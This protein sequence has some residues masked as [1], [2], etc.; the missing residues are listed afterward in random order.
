M[1][2]TK[3]QLKFDTKQPMFTKYRSL[4]IL[5]FA[6]F[7]L[8]ALLSTLTFV[9]SQ[10]LADA[11]QELD[12]AAY[13]TVLVQQISKELLDINLQIQ[14]ITQTKAGGTGD[15]EISID[16]LPQYSIYRLQELEH[17][18]NKFSEVLNAL[19]YGGTVTDTNGQTIHIDAIS[20]PRLQDIL[21]R[22][23]AIWIPYE[24]LLDNFNKDRQQGFIRKETSDYLVE[25]TRSYNTTLQ[26]ETTHFSNYLKGIIQ[27]NTDRL[28]LVQVFG[29]GIAF[30]LFLSIVF[31]ALRQLSRADV[32]LAKAREQTAEILA[33]VNEGLFLIDRNLVIANEYSDELENIIQQSK[34]GGKTLPQVLE[35]I[36]PAK[37]LEDTKTFIDQ[38][39]SDWVVED[40]IAD[41]NPLK[42]LKVQLGAEGGGFEER[43]LDFNFSRVYNNDEIVRVLVNVMDI[44]Q[45]VLLEQ[46]LEK[47]KAQNDR[48]MEMLGT[49][50]NTESALLSNFIQTTLIRVDKINGILKTP[51]GNI[52][53]LRSKAQ[54]IYRE[55]HSLKGE[56]SALR[57]ASFVALC[58]EIESKVK[59]LTDKFDLT[60][61]DFLSMTVNLEELLNLTLFIKSL[62]ERIGY[63]D[64][65]AIKERMALSLQSI[66]H[67]TQELSDFEYDGDDDI[68][69]DDNESKKITDIL[70]AYFRNFAQDIAHRHNK[71]V[72]FNSNGFDEVHLSS[73]QQNIIKDISIQLIRNA[74][75]HGI[76]TPDV[77]QAKDKPTAGRVQLSLNQ[78]GNTLNLVFIDDG[79]GINYDKI[80]QKAI[81][82]GHDADE[83]AAWEQRGLLNL[84]FKPGFSTADDVGE[85]AGRG[86]GMDIIKNLAKEL[87]GV[88]KVSSK[89]DQYTRFT[90]SFP[91]HS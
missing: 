2:D 27:L 53:I 57:L 24:G 81:E 6:F 43:Y 41:L 5:S 48:Q 61:A 21:T 28:R 33:T 39:Y 12:S 13:Q 4:I 58:Q 80:R 44:T 30:L 15:I 42:R 56:A 35:N 52:E 17:H 1:S 46:R 55:I 89:P 11:T 85:D 76:E 84:L 73:Q 50:V 79:Q 51:G 65:D 60:G 20:T 75:V 18:A 14:N 63:I 70:S 78:D 26:N 54:D 23:E 62:S 88:L 86:V 87:D 22:I 49:I 38:L 9:A 45:A 40:L 90:I 68:V 37:D 91:S 66:H 77:R 19:K 8:V 32:R 71:Q 59:R 47:E 10:Q 34:L 74:I 72:K 29:I 64:S 82:M 67:D 25:Y 83:V 69:I 7:I 31:G 36:V 16:S 3:S